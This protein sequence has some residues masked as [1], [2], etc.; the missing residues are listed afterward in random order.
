MTSPCVSPNVTVFPAS[1]AF[2]TDCK[3]VEDF[4]Q[5][6]EFDSPPGSFSFTSTAPVH[7]L[8]HRTETVLQAVCLGYDCETECRIKHKQGNDLTLGGVQLQEVVFGE[9]FDGRDLC[10]KCFCSRG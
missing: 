9:L 1:V 3:H 7:L 8:E 6:S 5:S 10:F 2:A 4:T